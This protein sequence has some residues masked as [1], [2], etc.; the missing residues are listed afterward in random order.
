MINW[1]VRFKNPVWWAEVAAAILLPMLAAVGV[2]WEDITSW[3]ALWA[4]IKAAFLNPVTL[5]AVAVSVWNTVTDPTTKGI[6]DSKAALCY[7]KPH[8]GDEE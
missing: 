8:C 4:V 3:A 6:C 7:E 5:A 1:K 2:G